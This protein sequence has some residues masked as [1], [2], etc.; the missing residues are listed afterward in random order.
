LRKASER[1]GELRIVSIE[2]LDR[3]ACGGTHVRATGEIGP[4]LIRK[5]DRIRGN[6]RVE[7][8]CGLRAIRRARADFE[9]LSQIGR[10][11]ST[12]IDDACTLV[13]QQA[14]RLGEADKALRRMAVELAALKGRQAYAETDASEDG[15][16]RQIRRLESSGIDDEARAF[17]HGFTGGARS[18]IVIAAPASRGILLA[19]SSDSGIHAADRL[20][21]LLA[22]AGGKGGG[23]SAIAQGSVSS[24]EALEDL[25]QKVFQNT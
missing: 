18:A 17:A 20:K 22:E 13:S 8:V 6:V 19:A 2:G 10:A 12:T 24:P 23:N 4:V 21:P 16:R 14:Q 3:S 1:Q 5:L 7:F 25:I 9:V 15:V 11:L